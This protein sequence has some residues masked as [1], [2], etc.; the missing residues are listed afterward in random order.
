M[1][2]SAPAGSL[3]G[4]RILVVED[5]PVSRELALSMA[6]AGEYTAEQRL[7]AFLLHLRERIGT[8]IDGS[9]RLP[10]AQRD[11]GNY[12]RLANETVCRTLK[13]FEQ[14]GWIITGTR[15]LKLVDDLALREAAAAV[16]IVLERASNVAK[17]RPTG[18]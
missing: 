12:L 2:S 13:R 15:G 6:L 7:A 9:L 18:F 11:I 4:A 5:E 1:A 10:M 16:G 3:K 8:A 17:E 14:K